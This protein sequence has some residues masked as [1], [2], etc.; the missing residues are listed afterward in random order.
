MVF[1]AA[2]LGA[3]PFQL[4][5]RMLYRKTRCCRARMYGGVDAPIQQ[6]C[7]SPAIPTDEKLTGMIPLWRGT[8]DIGIETFNAVNQPLLQ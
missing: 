8:A 5:G 4:D 1:V 7:R 2:A 6:L 3:Q